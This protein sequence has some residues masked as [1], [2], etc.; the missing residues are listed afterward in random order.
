M[1]AVLQNFLLLLL[2]LECLLLPFSSTLVKYL[3]DWILPEGSPLQDTALTGG[4]LALL[5]N[6]VEANGRIT[7]SS[8]LRYGINYGRKKFK[9]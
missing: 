6:R 1:G 5:A 4:S 7:H 9:V 3:Q 2:L 8:L